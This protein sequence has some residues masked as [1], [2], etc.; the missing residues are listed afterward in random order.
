M[1]GFWSWWTFLFLPGFMWRLGEMMHILVSSAGAVCQR[2]SCSVFMFWY[3]FPL[4]YKWG[5]NSYLDG[6]FLP[7]K[8]PMRRDIDSFWNLWHQGKLVGNGPCR[9]FSIHFP[10]YGCNLC[11]LISGGRSFCLLLDTSR[12]RDSLLFQNA[13]TIFKPY[14]V[15]IHIELTPISLYLWLNV[16][17]WMRL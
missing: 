9:C 11:K 6:P 16:L 7:G 10:T 3:S 14:K 8:E 5:P 2:I 15:L 4:V 1:T 17:W 13:Y 12:A